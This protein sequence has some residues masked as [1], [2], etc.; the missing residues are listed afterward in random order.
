GISGTDGTD[1][2]D[3]KEWITG[4]TDATLANTQAA[5][6]NIAD[7]IA[8]AAGTL[9]NSQNIVA[10]NQKLLDSRLT[11]VTESEGRI[12]NVD[13]ATESSRLARSELL[14]QN[15][16]SSITYNRS[17]AAFSVSSLFG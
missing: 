2:K 8:S 5:V 3:L 12:S 9:G 13:M 15:A 1:S 14:A 4:I 17:Y 10:Q 7:K 16:M 11:S 6:R